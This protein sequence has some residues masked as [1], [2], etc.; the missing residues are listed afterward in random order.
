MQARGSCDAPVQAE[1]AEVHCPAT[2][3]HAALA[4]HKGDVCKLAR[5]EVRQSCNNNQTAQQRQKTQSK[6][7]AKDPKQRDVTWG[8]MTQESQDSF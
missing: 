3:N 7:K 8:R 5:K 4:L 2:N 6:E 1:T